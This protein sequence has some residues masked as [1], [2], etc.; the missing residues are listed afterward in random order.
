ML[1]A[2]KVSLTFFEAIPLLLF[3]VAHMVFKAIAIY[4]KAHDVIAV[5]V[6]YPY[7]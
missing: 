6:C 7:L 1:K 5:C 4:C 2:K 3:M